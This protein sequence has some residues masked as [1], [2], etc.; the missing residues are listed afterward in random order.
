MNA[1]EQANSIEFA[2]K[3]AAVVGLFKAEFPDLRADLKPWANDPDTRNHIDPDSID[4]GFHLP[5]VSRLFQ[6]RSLLV[7]IRLYSDPDLAC[8]RNSCRVIGL[9]LAGF[10]HRGKRW[11]LSTI[12]DWT[13]SG[14]V[15][16]DPTCR[17]RLRK[18]CR[19]VFAL[20]NA[21]PQAKP[22]CA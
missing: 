11:G 12:D 15:I 17:E 14:E 9:D 22:P 2:S 16:P 4:V 5:G 8:D 13:F 1:A 7:Q 6:C 10:D 19:Q 20:F 3:I 21:P 18:C